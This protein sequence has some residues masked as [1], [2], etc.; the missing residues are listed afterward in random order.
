MH[1]V[2]GE[3]KDKI[4]EAS[5]NE[6]KREANE[7]NR[8]PG[9]T[10]TLR[11]LLSQMPGGGQQLTREMDDISQQSRAIDPNQLSP[12]ELHATLFKILA[13]RDKVCMAIE[14]GI[15]KV[16]GL[17]ALLEKITNALVASP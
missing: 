3:A 10:A 13:F 8:N 4:S 17:G 1:S 14:S 11:N 9:S 2:L 12:Q 6:L 15:E 16:P 5:V 7:A